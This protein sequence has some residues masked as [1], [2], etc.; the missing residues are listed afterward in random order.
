MMPWSIRDSTFILGSK[1]RL[2][3]LGNGIVVRGHKPNQVR[4]GYHM[5]WQRL[6]CKE[7][8]QSYISEAS[9]RSVAS[10]LRIWTGRDCCDWSRLCHITS[11]ILVLALDGR[12]W[13]YWYHAGGCNVGLTHCNAQERYLAL[14]FH[15]FAYWRATIS[16]YISW[17]IIGPKYP[18]AF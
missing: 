6:P 8:W 4:T 12:P 11:H 10:I 15:V 18:Q 17:M 2:A 9:K 1:L 3:K 13:T 7:F 16:Y 5:E 14:I